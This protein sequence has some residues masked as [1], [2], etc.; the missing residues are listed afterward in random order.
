MSA[1]L[2]VWGAGLVAA[3]AL[4]GLW[5]GL[6]MKQF[7]REGLGPIARLGADG[8]LA[9]IWAAALPVYLLLVA[10]NALFVLPRVGSAGWPVA[11]GWGAL[12]GLLIYGVYDLT[13]LA[14][15]RSY[16]VTLAAVDITWGA[17]ATALVSL[18]MR[19]VS[20]RGV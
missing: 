15:L 13:N 7:Y 9:P 5:L 19:A 6:V 2:K 12:F 10:G 8:S 3:M 14:T 1:W 16:S 11:A 17:V 18:V 20:G 4:D